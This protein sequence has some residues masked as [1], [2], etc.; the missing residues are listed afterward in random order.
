MMHNKQALY[1]VLNSN[2]VEIDRQIEAVKAQAERQMHNYL[3]DMTVYSM[4]HSDGKF[5]L[6]DLLV[7]KANTLAAMA[8]L[9]TAGDKTR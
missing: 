3:H 8:N 7:A 6:T 1:D 2:L 5:M 4:M 9:K